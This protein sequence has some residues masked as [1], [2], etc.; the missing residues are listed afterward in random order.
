[1]LIVIKKIPGNESTIEVADNSTVIDVK[2]VVA[3]QLDVPIGHQKLVFKGKTLSDNVPLKEYDISEGVKIHLFVTESNQ[4]SADDSQLSSSTT[5]AKSLFWDQLTQAL[6]KYYTKS[7]TVKIVD[8][9][10]RQLQSEVN[11]MSLDDI[12][13]LA[14]HKL[15]QQRQQS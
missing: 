12:E 5:T 2:Q 7:D 1:M 15:V 11:Q 6:Q 10:R 14:K 3:K 13:R 8:E 9:F 4:S